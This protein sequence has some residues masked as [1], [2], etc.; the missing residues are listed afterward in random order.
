MHSVPRYGAPACCRRVPCM[1]ARSP[2]PCAP[3]CDARA[4]GHTKC[5][6]GGLVRAVGDPHATVLPLPIKRRPCAD[7]TAQS[8]RRVLH[9]ARPWPHQLVARRLLPRIN[10]LMLRQFSVV[11]REAESSTRRCS[12]R[13]KPPNHQRG[14]AELTW[15]NHARADTLDTRSHSEPHVPLR[16]SAGRPA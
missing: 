11:G 15:P 7:R 2:L 9:D 16:G 10:S 1:L 3:A 12:R 4:L 8:L 14:E 6:Q 5:A 13:A